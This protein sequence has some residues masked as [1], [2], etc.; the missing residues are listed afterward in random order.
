MS[1]LRRFW[2]IWQGR[3]GRP[4]AE[5]TDLPWPPEPAEPLTRYLL[6]QRQFYRARRTVSASAFV[7]G[8]DGRLSVFRTLGLGEPGIWA[9]GEEEVTR[10]PFR[11]HGRADLA[12]QT[13]YDAGISLAP[14]PPPSRHADLADW[15]ADESARLLTATQLADAAELRLNP[16]VY[17]S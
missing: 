6:S 11:L 8:N 5:P 3:W 7:P 13:A 15:P 10:P 16:S 12:I 9:L 17:P 2:Q 14:D 1:F 4:Q